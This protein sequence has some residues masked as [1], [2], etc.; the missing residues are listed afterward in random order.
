MV[1]CVE[2]FF[3]NEV[4][5]QMGVWYVIYWFWLGIFTIGINALHEQQSFQVHSNHH[6]IFFGRQYY[7]YGLVI[8]AWSS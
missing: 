5:A 1:Y 3:W 4:N 2:M 8:W 7:I 6:R